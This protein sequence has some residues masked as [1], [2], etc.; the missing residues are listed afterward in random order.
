MDDVAAV[1][2]ELM[3]RF[4]DVLKAV[5]LFKTLPRQ[6][7]VP[8][9]TM[10]V[11]AAID[12]MTSTNGKQ[13]ATDCA[14]DPSTISRSVNALVKADLVA[15]T[16]DPDDGRASVLA[17]SPAGRVVLDDVVRV[18]DERLAHAL[19][20]WSADDMRTLNRLLKRLSDD[21]TAPQKTLETL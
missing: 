9:G 4:G 7:S 12:R 21:L 14:L 16:A 6:D 10:S 11:L 8:T 1:R 19:H 13:L 15:R 18:Y 3:V 20:D 2:R 17:V 5:R